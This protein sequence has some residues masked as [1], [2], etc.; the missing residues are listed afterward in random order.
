MPE[1]PSIHPGNP[2]L[3]SI[4]MGT[5]MANF[6]PQVVQ[7]LQNMTPE[8]RNLM[9]SAIMRQQRERQLAVSLA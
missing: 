8:Q 4:P 1:L 3:S 7:Q 9:M 2:S 6:P 5:P